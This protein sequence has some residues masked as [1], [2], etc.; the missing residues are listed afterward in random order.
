MG[1][2]SRLRDTLPERDQL[3]FRVHGSAFGCSPRPRGFGQLLA[4]VPASLLWTAVSPL[5]ALAYLAAIGILVALI[6]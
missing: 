3:T 2:S 6:R 4:S 5:A 1:G